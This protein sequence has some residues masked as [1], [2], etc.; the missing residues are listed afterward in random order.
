MQIIKLYYMSTKDEN[1]MNLKEKFEELSKI[2][3]EDFGG[4]VTVSYDDSPEANDRSYIDPKGAY[5]R[6]DAEFMISY[7]YFD[8]IV[9]M[10]DKQDKCLILKEFRVWGGR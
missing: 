5:N 3:N 9:S 10:F 6:A 4:G 1:Q 8:V 7:M 2:V